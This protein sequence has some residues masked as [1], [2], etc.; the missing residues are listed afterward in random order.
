M[1]TPVQSVHIKARNHEKWTTTGVVVGL[2]LFFAL[3]IVVSLTAFR[4]EDSTLGQ[5]KNLPLV[6]LETSSER[7][8][9]S[10]PTCQVSF[11]YPAN[12]QIGQTAIPLP[13]APLHAV[14]VD[15]PAKAPQVGQSA[16][17][18]YICLDAKQYTLEQLLAGNSNL[19][20]QVEKI[21]GKQWQRLGSFAAS[22][23]G[24]KLLVF[25]M[26]FTKYDLKPR[27]SYE[28]VFLSILQSVNAA[29]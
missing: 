8:K 19:K 13:G 20:P 17:L 18:S 23:F 28:E 10:D 1:I 14:T 4:Q 16:I 26:P 21:G 25:Y 7:Q 2:I 29:Y 12:W 11:A 5:N 3:L 24:D 6:A 15:G 9:Y 22:T 27:P